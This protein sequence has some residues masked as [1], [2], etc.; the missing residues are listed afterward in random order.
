MVKKRYCG[1]TPE[2]ELLITGL[3]I[4]RSDWC[5]LAKEI[6][7]YVIEKI[8][9]GTT[10]K[11]INDYLKKVKKE[12]DTY[13]VEKFIFEKVVDTRKHMKVRTTLVKVWEN[14]GN[15]VNKIYGDRVE[16]QFVSPHGETLLGVRW[17]YD[18]RG[19]II[20]IPEDIPIEKIRNK[21]G[22]NYYWKKQ[23]IPVV[24]RV[25]QAIGW[26]IG[27]QQKTLDGNLLYV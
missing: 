2:G 23:I 7:Y 15:K 1:I 10:E 20:A 14:L 6:Q 25:I 22:Y 24:K 12:M 27:E 16:Y 9:T 26:K 19:N 8:L 18:D 13:P 3:E 21:I 4:K 5:L 11:E 17:I